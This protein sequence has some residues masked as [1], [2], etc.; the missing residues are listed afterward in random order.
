MRNRSGL[1]GESPKRHEERLEYQR[2]RL[3]FLSANPICQ[4]CRTLKSTCIE[5]TAGRDGKWLL[6]ERYWKAVCGR[7]ADYITNH[8]KEAMRRGFKVL[9]RI[10]ERKP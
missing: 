6:D 2:R 9:R 5:H 1:R 3:I 8:G 10:S 7:C 4:F